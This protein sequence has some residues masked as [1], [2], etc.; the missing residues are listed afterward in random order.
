MEDSPITEVILKWADMPWKVPSQTWTSKFEWRD[1]RRPPLRC[2][3]M[4][5]AREGFSATMSTVTA[6]GPMVE[7]Q[8]GAGAGFRRDRSE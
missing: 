6:G 8:A 3:A 7:A 1:V 2:S 5:G 4:G